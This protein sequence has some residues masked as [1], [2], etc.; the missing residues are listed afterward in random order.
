MSSHR[1]LIWIYLEHYS[2]YIFIMP[3]NLNLNLLLKL[4]L[5]EFQSQNLKKLFL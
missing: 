3:D 4:F 1:K 2:S 5:E